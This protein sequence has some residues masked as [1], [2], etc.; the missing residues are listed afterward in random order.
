LQ[1]SGADRWLLFLAG[2][3]GTALL[4]AEGLPRLADVV[5]VVRALVWG[6]AACG[7]IASVQFWSGRD[8]AALIGQSLPGFT[9]N[10]AI[11]GI[12]QRGGLN[13]VPGTMLH[14]IELGTVACML[15]PLAVVLL[16]SDGGRPLWRRLVPLVLI[17]GCIPVSVSR[18]AILAAAVTVVVFV[19]QLGAVRR[20]VAVVVLPF[21]LSGIFL[22]APGV[23]STLGS[24]V[25]NSQAD[26]SVT[27]RTDDY[28]LVE[29]LVRHDP[30]LGQGGG[31]YLPDNPLEILDNA[32]LTWV[33]EFGLL[34]L[35]L[36]VV[37]Y[38]VLPVITGVVIR[39]RAAAA[40]AGSSLPA[41]DLDRAGLLGAAIS[42]ALAG[43][44][45]SSATFDSLAFPTFA[46]LQALLIGLLGALWQLVS[47]WPRQAA[48]LPDADRSP[49]AGSTW[50]S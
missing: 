4:A 16:V 23:I 11:S 18:S 22:S 37:F 21:A 34:G 9:Y 27:A 50:T 38:I 12:Q 17:A 30:W 7:A 6:G 20:A 39:R 33:V 43:A 24:Y 15:L 3:T 1:H 13:R 28:T 40:A 36:L 44:A 25:A 26:T 14:P 48:D 42:A 29:S 5:R 2:M 35:A 8:F 32:Y 10:G 19:G 45:V 49:R 47:P 46:C 31:T 41:A